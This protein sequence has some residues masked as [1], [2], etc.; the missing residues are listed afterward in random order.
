[1]SENVVSVVYEEIRKRNIKAGEKSLP[2]SDEIVKFLSAS[3]V[4]PENLIQQILSILVAAN[5]IFVLEIV[6]ED[7][8]RNTPRIEG[9]VVTDLTI[10]RKMKS[11]FQNELVTMYNDEFNKHLMFHKV[12]KEIF[13]IIRSLNNTPV[14]QVANKAIMLGEFEKLMERNFKEY[15]DDNT[16]KK[17]ELELSK[18]NL[19][20]PSSEKEKDKS[21]PPERR[22]EDAWIDDVKDEPGN[23]RAIDGKVYKDFIS[24]SNNYPL[25]RILNIYGIKF[26]IQVY[27][28]K[29]DF[30][31]IKLLIKDQQIS[32]R[33]DLI[34]LKEM[35]RK[36]KSNI[37]NDPELIKHIEEIYDLERTISHFIYFSEK[38]ASHGFGER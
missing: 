23:Q 14:G 1:M 21:A 31:Y 26:F 24:K 33:S 16:R 29:Y 12:V 4:M 37:D 25:Q 10:V 34:L 19:K 30:G 5:R 2:H 22:P 18:A 7:K 6:A 11:F 27:L 17:L 28:R 35:L 8:V 32:R 15:L 9:Y 3:I 13:P 20:I 38:S 36:V